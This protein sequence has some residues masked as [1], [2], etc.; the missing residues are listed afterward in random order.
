[1]IDFEDITTPGYPFNAHASFYDI[2]GRLFFNSMLASAHLTDQD[3]LDLLDPEE[4]EGWVDG[5][6]IDAMQQAASGSSVTKTVDATRQLTGLSTVPVRTKYVFQQ[7]GLLMLVT[8]WPEHMMTKITLRPDLL[9]MDWCPETFAGGAAGLISSLRGKACFDPTMFGITTLAAGYEA[10]KVAYRTQ[11]GLNDTAHPYGTTYASWL[12]RHQSLVPERRAANLEDVTFDDLANL[13]DYS[14]KAAHVTPPRELDWLATDSAVGDVQ[15]IS[16]IGAAWRNAF[17]VNPDLK[18]LVQYTNIMTIDE[19]YYYSPDIDF[20][21]KKGG[22]DAYPSFYIKNWF[23][24][25][26]AKK[27]ISY[28]D[29]YPASETPVMAN[30]GRRIDL[31][32]RGYSRPWIGASIDFALIDAVQDILALTQCGQTIDDDES[33]ERFYIDCF[34]LNDLA[35]VVMQNDVNELSSGILLSDSST[36]DFSTMYPAIF[37]FL[38][39]NGVFVKKSVID[40]TTLQKRDTFSL[41]TTFGKTIKMIKDDDVVQANCITGP[42]LSDDHYAIVKLTQTT[43]LNRRIAACRLPGH[44]T[45]FLMTQNATVEPDRFVEQVF[46]VA[47]VTLRSS[48]IFN[49]SLDTVTSELSSETPS[50]LDRVMSSWIKSG[51]CAISNTSK[52]IELVISTGLVAIAVLLAVVQVSMC[53]ARV[54]RWKK[55]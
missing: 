30:I 51:S 55:K 43:K 31:L 21:T 42:Q 17:V 19:A 53:C 5:G 1:M 27:E 52:P 39:A 14:N 11:Y 54:I 34:M 6:F 47:D 9:V 23:Y 41:S 24:F 26:F 50:T 48:P 22:P 4:I 45:L 33:G 40:F 36:A 3:S 15:T 12:P 18:S 13:T 49:I 32:D 38:L 16:I 20:L 46:T 25:P 8:S 28:T 29:P 35:H 10:D 37:H 44:D 7:L 2:N